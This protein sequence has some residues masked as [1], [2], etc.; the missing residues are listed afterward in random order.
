MSGLITEKQEV[1]PELRTQIS[2]LRGETG[3]GAGT[4]EF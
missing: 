4:G 2:E 3:D 1:F